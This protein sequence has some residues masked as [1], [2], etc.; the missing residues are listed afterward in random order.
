M[1]Q[2]RVHVREASYSRFNRIDRKSVSN[3]NNLMPSNRHGHIKLYTA[4]KTHHHL[5]LFQEDEGQQV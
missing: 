1:A 2:I 4:L 3:V 5:N